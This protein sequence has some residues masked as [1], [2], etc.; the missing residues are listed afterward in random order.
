M[1]M[2]RDSRRVRGED[3]SLWPPDGVLAKDRWRRGR[4]HPPMAPLAA[5]V[6]DK[7]LGALRASRAFTSGGV[8]GVV[9]V[10]AG[11]R[12]AAKVSRRRVLES[13]GQPDGP[14]TANGSASHDPI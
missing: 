1:I 6:V 12:R 13:L 3:Q 5:K 8:P 9:Q 7:V 11:R 2:E 4:I 10:H 14:P